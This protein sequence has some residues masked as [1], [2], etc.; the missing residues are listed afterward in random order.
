MA[1]RYTAC[2]ANA[3]HTIG[4][5][6]QSRGDGDC[7]SDAPESIRGLLTAISLIEI[8]RVPAL[9]ALPF[10]EAGPFAVCVPITEGA[11][12][13]F[14]GGGGGG[15]VCG[16]EEEEGVGQ[17]GKHTQTPERDLGRHSAVFASPLL[18]TVP[19]P[20]YCPTVR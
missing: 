6:N 15:G 19:V 5:G 13:G 2:G 4:L 8:V 17:G 3:V 16:G 12:G 14:S 20:A 18:H 9:N 10:V 1:R 11:R 7:R